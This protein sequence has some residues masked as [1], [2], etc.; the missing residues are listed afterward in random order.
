M[1]ISRID[2]IEMVYSH[3]IISCIDKEYYSREYDGKDYSIENLNNLVGLAKNKCPWIYQPNLKT[4]ISIS[5]N[6][7]KSYESFII[8]L[9]NQRQLSDEDYDKI[10]F[11]PK[12]MGFDIKIDLNLSDN[13]YIFNIE[14]H[15]KDNLNLFNL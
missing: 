9:N 4:Y 1:E 3:T 12:F 6:N 13:E 7:F 2:E 5:H 8:L 10:K 15:K 11:T 14:F